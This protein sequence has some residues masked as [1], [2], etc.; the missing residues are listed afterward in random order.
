MVMTG[1]LANSNN[2]AQARFKSQAQRQARMNEKKREANAEC[3]T[4]GESRKLRNENAELRR[5]IAMLTQGNSSSDFSSTRTMPRTLLAL[6]R[7]PNPLQVHRSFVSPSFVCSKLSLTPSIAP[8]PENAVIDVDALLGDNDSDGFD[9]AD[10]LNSDFM[11]PIF[12]K[13]IRD[14]PMPGVDDDDF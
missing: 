14:H 3:I 7:G 11:S 1:V 13:I 10:A 5:Q 8:H 6:R 4:R 2:S 9:W 12:K